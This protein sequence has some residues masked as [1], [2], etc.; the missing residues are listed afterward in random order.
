MNLKKNLQMPNASVGRFGLGW[1]WFVVDENKKLEVM[2]TA[3]QDNPI[4]E[5]KTDILCLDV[6]E[7]AY[8]LN[9]QNRRPEY[10]SNFLM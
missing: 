2:S 8:Y 4:M 7:H 9:Y 5:G 1:A 6:W 10:I 3:N